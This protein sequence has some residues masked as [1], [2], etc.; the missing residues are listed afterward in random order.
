MGAEVQRVSRDPE[1]TGAS[2]PTHCDPTA[3]GPWLCEQRQLRGLSRCFVAARTR[4]APE[5]IEAIERGLVALGDDTLGRGAARQLAC[6]VGADPQEALARMGAQPAP[7]GRM[8]RRTLATPSRS[9]PSVVRA[10]LLWTGGLAGLALSGALLWLGAAWLERGAPSAG[11]V[12]RP[13]YVEHLLQ[14]RAP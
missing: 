13:D 11:I 8:L 12:Y 6:A 9:G 1:V 4:I 2:P 3:F 7:A 5:R 10:L 14:R